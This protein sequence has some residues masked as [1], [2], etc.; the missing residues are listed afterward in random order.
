[1]APVDW[2]GTS[3]PSWG[4][5]A[6]RVPGDD[7]DALTLAVEAGRAALA[8]RAGAQR[9]VLVSRD[10]PLLEGGNA[11]VLLAWLGPAPANEAPEIL[12]PAPAVV[13]PVRSPEALP[14]PDLPDQAPA[15]Q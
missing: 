3:L 5:R 12:P 13:V 14:H 4:T 11:A 6:L 1:M 9:V 7:E 8:D 10:L 2:I 15:P